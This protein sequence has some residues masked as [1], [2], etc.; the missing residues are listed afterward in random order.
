MIHA[1]RPVSVPRPISALLGFT[2]GFVDI[3]SFLGLFH[4]FVAQVTGSFVFTSTWLVI[5]QG[6]LVT[7]VA[8]PTFFVAACLATALA[9]FRAPDGRP[10]VWV[11]GLECALIAA[12]LVLM[13]S[14]PLDSATAPAT[15][16]TTL[17]GI[18]AMGVQSTMVRLFM[19]DVPSTNV[20]TTNT[21]QLAMDTT[22]LLLA[23]GRQPADEAEARQN[24]AAHDRLHCH[25]PPIAGFVLGTG[26]GALCFQ[27]VGRPALGVALVG[28]CGFL[29]WCV[30]A[31]RPATA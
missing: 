5:R 21:T 12:M 17:L 16:V 7:M 14:L 25:W 10:L 2:A 6:E 18:S 4:I 29:I 1:I 24:R 23:F 13:L 27:L 15:V 19:R 26:I 20:M 8:I 9:A 3:C 11:A 31:T 30:R 28:A 22:L